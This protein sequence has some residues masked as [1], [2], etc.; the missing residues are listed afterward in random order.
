MRIKEFAH[1]PPLRDCRFRH[2]PVD[3]TGIAADLLEAAPGP[4]VA[5][6]RGMPERNFVY[7]LRSTT[8]QDRYYVGLTSDL[9]TRLETSE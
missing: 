8:N 3:P 4:A 6:G 9:S 7:V 5:F 2:Q 1:P